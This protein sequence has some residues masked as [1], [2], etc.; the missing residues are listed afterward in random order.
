M[1]SF[2]SIFLLLTCL[3]FGVEAYAQKAPYQDPYGTTSKVNGKPRTKA[4]SGH[5]KKTSKGQ[6]RVNPYYKSK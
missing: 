5:T 1:K 2:L 3:L 4:V 6:V